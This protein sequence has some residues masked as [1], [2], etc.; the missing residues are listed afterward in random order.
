MVTKRLLTEE[1]LDK[2]LDLRET[3]GD[4]AAAKY[5]ASLQHELF[6]LEAIP[7]YMKKKGKKV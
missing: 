2:F 5:M 4:K 1:E 6:D 7:E 3:K